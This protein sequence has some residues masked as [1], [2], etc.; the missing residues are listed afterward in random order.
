MKEVL[1]FLSSHGIKFV[2]HEHPAVFTCAA[3]DEHCGDIPGLACKNLLLRDQK[4]RRYLL[5]VLPAEKRVDLK[6]LG[7]LVGDK[8]SF[9]SA[10][11]L[12]SKLG[13][14]VGSVSPFGLLND[15]A[16][17]VE[18]FV[19]REVYDADIVSFHPNVNTAT[20]ELPHD[21]FLK[22]LDVMP[23]DVKIL[24]I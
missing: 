18:L 10:E 2:L 23:H 21:E 17:E 14:E 1:D 24:N 5:V 9:A 13:L 6:A 8:L 4:K 3:A 15:T 11:N 22:F 19:D 16:A 7:T 20:L 12:M